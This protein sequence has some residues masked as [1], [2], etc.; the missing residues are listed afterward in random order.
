MC[1]QFAKDILV[2]ELSTKDFVERF[3]R[4]RLPVVITGVCDSWKG[5]EAWTE[6]GLLQRY[7]EHKFK[8]HQSHLNQL[9]AK[10]EQ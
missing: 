9:C 2:Q 10:L 3:E 7:S 1:R 6:E 5:R 4:S 8:V